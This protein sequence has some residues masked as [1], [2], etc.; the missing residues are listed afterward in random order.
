M[1]KAFRNFFV[2]FYLSSGKAKTWK[3]GCESWVEILLAWKRLPEHLFCISDIFMSRPFLSLPIE[4][5][6]SLTQLFMIH[7]MKA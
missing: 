4:R 5:W 3:D 6:F 2:R 7:F 1:V